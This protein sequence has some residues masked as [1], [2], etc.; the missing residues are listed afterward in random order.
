MKLTFKDG[1]VS[2]VQADDNVEFVKNIIASDEGS[3]RVG[4]FAFGTNPYVN[5]CTNRYSD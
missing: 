4:E 3:N 5:V 2:E 1:V